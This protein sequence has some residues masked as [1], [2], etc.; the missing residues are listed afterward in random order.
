MN[1][2][3]VSIVVPVFKVERF[4]D[5]CV[6]S[7]INQTLRD[8]EI[9]LV[10][11]GSQ[12]GSPAICDKWAKRDERIRVIHKH[13]EGLG[14]TR[15]AGL[16]VAQ[17]EYVAFVDSDDYVDLNMME[18]LYTE[19]VNYK[20]DCIYSEF[21]VDD[22]PGFR[23][24]PRPEKLYVGQEE[25]EQLRLD[26]VGAEP[27]FISGVKYHCSSCKGL[28]SLKIIK[29]YKLH[30]LSERQYISEDMIFNLD[31]LGYSK[32]VKTVPWQFYHYCLNGT[33]LTHTY[34]ADRWEKQMKMIDVINDRFDF[35]DNRSFR[36]RLARTAIFYLMCATRVERK[37]NDIGNRKKIKRINDLLHEPKIVEVLKVYPIWNLPYKWVIYS[38]A[39][40]YKLSVLVFMLSL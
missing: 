39:A 15:N 21:N 18:K 36:L 5:R 12:D 29:E 35:L 31:F 3:K 38:V 9:V 2:I 13:N 30:F 8:I 14:L 11:D 7:L 4:L 19:C 28:Y 24:V 10:D 37:R 17:G 6:S 33:S 23:V 22:Y 1:N 40:K 25:I 20:L 27:G 26:I 32:R 34:R 16:R